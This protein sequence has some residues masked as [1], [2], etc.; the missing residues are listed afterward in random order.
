MQPHRFNGL[1][2]DKLFEAGFKELLLSIQNLT[3]AFPD[4]HNTA[5]G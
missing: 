2:G 3:K 4:F 1:L 5:L